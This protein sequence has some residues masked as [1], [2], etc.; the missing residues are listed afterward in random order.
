MMGCSGCRKRA[1]MTKGQ[2]V[3]RDHDAMETLRREFPGSYWIFDGLELRRVEDPS[4]VYPE[5]EKYADP[6][7]AITYWLE[8]R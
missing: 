5:R 8:L 4:H 3:K 6:V 2:K 1:M 7:D